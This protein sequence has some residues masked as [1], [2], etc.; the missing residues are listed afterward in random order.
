MTSFGMNTSTGLRNVPISD[1]KTKLLS[2]LRNYRDNPEQ[3]NYYGQINQNNKE[4]PFSFDYLRN[5]L[6]ADD[7]INEDRLTRLVGIGA[8]N[9]NQQAEQKHG[10]EMELERLKQGGTQVTEAWKMQDNASNRQSNQLIANLQASS[11]ERTAGIGANAN[12]RVGELGLAGQRELAAAQRESARYQ[13][14]AQRYLADSNRQSAELQS[15][16]S[17]YSSIMSRPAEWRYW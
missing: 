7:N 8:R 14:D 4:N 16:N 13:A 9:A 10:H 12:I 1:S 15:R 5:A 2:S 6:Y 17:L 11:N 3:Y